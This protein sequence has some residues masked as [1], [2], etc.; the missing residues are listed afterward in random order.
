MCVVAD[1]DGD[2]DDALVAF[3]FAGERAVVGDCLIGGE[4]VEAVLDE[5]GALHAGQHEA[6]FLAVE[7]G[8]HRLAAWD[9][10][11]RDVWV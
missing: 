1:A 10:R 5:V 4:V 3:F 8:L 2:A 7:L 6:A 9:R 11:L